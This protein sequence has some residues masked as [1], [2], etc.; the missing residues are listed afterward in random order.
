MSLNRKDIDSYLNSDDPK[1][2][3][4]IEKNALNDEF[5]NA[6]LDGWNDFPKANMS[7]LDKRFA[8]KSFW[9][10]KITTIVF[11]AAG[12][13]FVILNFESNENSQKNIQT[14]KKI[15]FYLFFTVVKGV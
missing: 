1:F 3:N 7:Q 4:T 12:L 11:L 9:G 5:D 14:T 13:A 15:M 2:K 8:K 10:I 6:A